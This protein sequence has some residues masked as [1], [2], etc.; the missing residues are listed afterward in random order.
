MN[1]TQKE[2]DIFNKKNPEKIFNECK[3][4]TSWV[5]VVEDKDGFIWKNLIDYHYVEKILY[6]KDSV[7]YMDY[8]VLLYYLEQ[9]GLLNDNEILE[10]TQ[11]ALL[12]IPKIYQGDHCCVI[13]I[14]NT[15]ACRNFS[16]CGNIQIKLYRT[17]E[18][19][20]QNNLFPCFK[21]N[22]HCMFLE[23]SNNCKLFTYETKNISTQNIQNK[24]FHPFCGSLLEL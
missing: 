24:I 23:S 17:K 19:N 15:I 1:F 9:S 16:K 21:G 10:N 18:K 22:L 2:V 7:S 20:F 8:Y 3:N 12:S 5:K 6:K 13:H 14:C 11:L 4:H